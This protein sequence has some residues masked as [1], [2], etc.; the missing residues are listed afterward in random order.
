MERFARE[1][2]RV[3][4]HLDVIR[5]KELLEL[6]LRKMEGLRG[7][8]GQGVGEGRGGVERGKGKGGSGGERGWRIF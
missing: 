5:R 8:E 2:Q 7:L 3:R 1:D 4:G 6:V